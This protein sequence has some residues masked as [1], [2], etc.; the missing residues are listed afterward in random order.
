M[1]TIIGRS[2]LAVGF[3]A[4][5]FLLMS[6]LIAPGE[7][8]PEPLDEETK[9]SIT[10]KDRDE[11]STELKQELPPPPKPQDTPPQLI[12][13]A[14]PKPSM[15]ND[16]P[17]FPKPVLGTEVIS[18]NINANRRAISVVAIPPE[19]PQGPL[20]KNIEGWVLLEFTIGVG[21]EVENIQ[22]VDAEPKGSFERAAIRAMKR[23][24]YQPKMVEG[25]PVAQH[26][27][28]EIFRFEIEK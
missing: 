20:S 18:S 22:V 14:I 6:Y 3:T 12:A 27:M 25:R 28:Q 16:G 15:N 1:F 21:G 9:I 19:Y 5:A 4:G 10:R 24:K 26:H 23:W 11:T 7:I 2:V 8:P 13:M 17:S